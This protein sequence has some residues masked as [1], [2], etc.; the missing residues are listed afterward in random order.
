[1]TKEPLKID[2][3]CYRGSNSLFGFSCTCLAWKQSAHGHKQH[4]LVEEEKMWV[5]G[6]VRVLQ[7]TLPCCPCAGMGEPRGWF[8]APGLLCHSLAIKATLKL[9]SSDHEVQMSLEENVIRPN[10]AVCAVP[11]GTNKFLS[12]YFLP[13]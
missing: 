7:R 5:E 8:S 11:V 13:L 12:S 1:M 4:C 9:T 3:N 10:E 2:L 6:G